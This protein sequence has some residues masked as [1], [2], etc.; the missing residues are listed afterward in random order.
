MAD[1]EII[2]PIPSGKD[3]RA[4]PPNADSVTLSAE[5]Q[6]NLDGSLADF[7]K[8]QAQENKEIEDELIKK[9]E[10]PFDFDLRVEEIR[11]NLQL[12]EDSTSPSPPIVNT[13]ERDNP[14]LLLSQQSIKNA[15]LEDFHKSRTPVIDVAKRGTIGGVKGAG[16]LLP[17]IA[18]FSVTGVPRGISS[19]G[20]IVSNAVKRAYNVGLEELEEVLGNTTSLDFM[21]G[22]LANPADF[23]DVDSIPKFFGAPG[24]DEMGKA[25]KT[26]VKTEMKEIVDSTINYIGDV[27]ERHRNDITEFFYKSAYLSMPIVPFVSGINLILKTPKFFKATKLTNPNL[28]STALVGKTATDMAKQSVVRGAGTINS[29]LGAGAA[30]QLFENMWKDTDLKDIAPLMAIPGAIIGGSTMLRAPFSLSVGTALYGIGRVL[31]HSATGENPS[32]L[33]LQSMA[34]SQ[35]LPVKD[36]M[37]M[38]TDQLVDRVALASNKHLQYMDDISKGIQSLPKAYK[39]P[40]VQAFAKMQ[41]FTNKYQGPQGERLTFFLHQI[42]GLGV[43]SAILK[44]DTNSIAMSLFT[45]KGSKSGKLTAVEQQNEIIQNNIRIVQHEFEKLLGQ[46]HLG[47][48]AADEYTQLLQ[49]MRNT[50]DDIAD[51]G[52]EL[53]NKLID[54]TDSGSVFTNVSK[55]E[56]I[57]EIAGTL[58]KYDKYFKEGDLNAFQIEA[59]AEK[60]GEKV[61]GLIGRAFTSAKTVVDEGYT[62]L[63]KLDDLV[64]VEGLVEFSSNVKFEGIISPLKSSTSGGRFLKTQADLINTARNNTLGNFN[65][66]QLEKIYDTISDN[67]D[68]KNIVYT[69]SKGNTL[70]TK[71][72][73]KNLK[74]M[75]GDEKKYEL[76]KILSNITT[77]NANAFEQLNKFIPPKFLMTDLLAYRTNLYT[78]LNRLRDTPE[79]HSIREVISEVDNALDTHFANDLLSKEARKAYETANNLYKERLL[80]FKSFTGTKMHDGVYQQGSKLFEDSI[81]NQ[82]MFAMFTQFENNKVMQNTFSKMFHSEADKAEAAELFQVTIGRILNNDIPKYSTSFVNK[83]T[84]E[85]IAAMQTAGMI[86]RDQFKGLK[87]VMKRR[88]EVKDALNSTQVFKDKDIFEKKTMPALLKMIEMSTGGKSELYKAIT[89]L[90]TP[91]KLIDAMLDDAKSLGKGFDLSGLTPTVKSAKEYLGK[92]SPELVDDFSEIF[93]VSNKSQYSSVTDHILEAI[94]QSKTLTSLEKIDNL[95]AIERL[96]IYRIY[97]NSFFITPARDLKPK[98]FKERRGDTEGLPL[99]QRIKPFFVAAS[100]SGLLSEINIVEMGKALEKAQGPLLKIGKSLDLTKI[101]A[102]MSATATSMTRM[103]MLKELLEVN[104]LTLSDLAKIPLSDIGG[105]MSMSSL[106]SRAFAVARGV[107]S[108]KFV[109]GDA[110]L[111]IQHQKKMQYMS[112]V[113]TRPETVKIMHDVLVKGKTISGEQIKYWKRLLVPIIGNDVVNR[114]DDKDLG[115]LLNTWFD[116]DNKMG[117]SPTDV[118]LKPPIIIHWPKIRYTQEQLGQNIKGFRRKK[119]EFIKNK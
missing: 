111:R 67:V 3:Y 108:L 93:S 58:F 83:L 50:L 106:L 105:A 80:P 27:P 7:A 109:A 17:D 47:K 84:D 94:T 42:T 32:R 54:M 62:A 11:K 103:N 31:G 30:W 41:Y 24:L 78:R 61:V 81:Q 99:S 52:T 15:Q 59:R 53:R 23:S 40:L 29:A 13:L 19:L 66:A 36:V 65:L 95:E 57:Q 114:L 25:V 43:Q 102:G 48:P 35:G 97:K 90:N 49:N 26:Y 119:E 89:S 77:D 98:T 22:D 69:T 37:L 110:F 75:T 79:G 116:A 68:L 117:V 101:N 115:T 71:V 100:D 85:K 88:D 39:E 1:S 82:D 34:F 72:L 76:Q 10:D 112:D 38:T 86:N 87:D 45:F 118:M 5:M 44:A 56:R 63:K 28:S 21:K 33:M 6:A 16:E 104:R 91:D 8:A 51:D 64:N 74:D 92:T 4:L 96:M 20:K 70:N 18:A 107:V 9:P 2:T 60:F 73:D 12:E 55:I 14:L 113:L 46:G